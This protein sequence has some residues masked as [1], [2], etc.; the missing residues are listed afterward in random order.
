MSYD[1]RDEIKSDIEIYI[2]DLLGGMKVS[3]REEDGKT[4]KLYQYPFDAYDKSDDIMIYFKTSLDYQKVI[5]DRMYNNRIVDYDSAEK[6][7]RFD[8]T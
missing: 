4:Y 1:Y 6:M 8:C 5:S 7:I 3:E 2:T